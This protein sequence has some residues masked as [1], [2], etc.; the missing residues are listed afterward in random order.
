MTLIKSLGYEDNNLTA[1]D[2]VSLGNGMDSRL[3]RQVAR[4]IH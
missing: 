1:R 4:R 3:Y 2:E